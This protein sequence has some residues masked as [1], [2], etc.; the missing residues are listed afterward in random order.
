MN[1]IERRFLVKGDFQ[2]IIW[3]HMQ[4]FKAT[5]VVTKNI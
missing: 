4:S 1:E 2:K 5:Y 3:N